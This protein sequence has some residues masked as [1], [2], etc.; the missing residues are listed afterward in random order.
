[1]TPP[2]RLQGVFLQRTTEFYA[3]EGTRLMQAT[4]VAEYLIHCEV[5]PPRSLN[6]MD[7]GGTLAACT[8]S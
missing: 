4:D 6:A 5:P 7:A 3:S 1:M 8:A 2:V